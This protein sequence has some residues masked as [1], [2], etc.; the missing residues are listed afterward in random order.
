MS[1]MH[2]NPEI[3]SSACRIM[4]VELKGEYRDA[5]NRN[6]TVKQICNQGLGLTMLLATLLFS[7]DHTDRLSIEFTMHQTQLRRKLSVK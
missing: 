1:K 5:T 2:D 3:C 7:A 6:T 4:L